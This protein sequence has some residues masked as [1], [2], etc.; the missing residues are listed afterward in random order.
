MAIIL[1]PTST[2]S[3]LYIFLQLFFAYT[4]ALSKPE[5]RPSVVENLLRDSPIIMYFYI[6]TPPINIGIPLLLFLLQIS[7]EYFFYIPYHINFHLWILKQ[8]PLFPHR[9]LHKNHS[10]TSQPTYL[11]TSPIKS[12]LLATTCTNCI[13]FLL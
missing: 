10:T 5:F 9:L 4:I 2:P 3:S 13:Q 1:S 6:S 8:P 11:I 7:L 12:H